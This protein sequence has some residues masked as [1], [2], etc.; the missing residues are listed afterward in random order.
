[1][2]EQDCSFALTHFRL[3]C[4]ASVPSQRIT[5]RLR[6][7]LQKQGVSKCHVCTE[8][9]SQEPR[10][11]LAKPVPGIVSLGMQVRELNHTK[12]PQSCGVKGRCAPVSSIQMGS[13]VLQGVRR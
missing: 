5:P 9:D 1:M 7:T 6:N 3:S 10:N 2:Q 13:P 11:A 12:K 4:D 8:L